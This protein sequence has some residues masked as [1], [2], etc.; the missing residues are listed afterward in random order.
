MKPRPS[1]IKHSPSNPTLRSSNNTQA[2]SSQ[3]SNSPLHEE[4]AAGGDSSRHTSMSGTSYSGTSR[5]SSLEQVASL[6]ALSLIQQ[7]PKG[8]I[9]TVSYHQRALFFGLMTLPLTIFSPKH[10]C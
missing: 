2:A 3:T 10:R 4:P 5:S 7:M 6:T 1:S 8:T 9:L